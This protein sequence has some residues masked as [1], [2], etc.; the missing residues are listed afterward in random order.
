MLEL[1]YSQALMHPKKYQEKIWLY[2]AMRSV[3]FEHLKL[4]MAGR[5]KPQT[6]VKFL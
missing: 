3:C 2:T 4:M 5:L 6:V 1:Q